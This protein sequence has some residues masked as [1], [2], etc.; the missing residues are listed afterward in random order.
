MPVEQVKAYLMDEN[1][2]NRGRGMY[3]VT[4][5]DEQAK[6]LAEGKAIA[7]AG[8][9]K[10]GER[11]QCCVQFDAAQRQ[12]VLCHPNWFKEAQK[13]GMDMGL[14]QQQKREQSQEQQQKST[15]EQ[16]PKKSAGLKK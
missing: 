13:A 15:Q 6:A 5:S 2:V 7:I 1:G 14:N 9:R 16:G 8:E 3:G 4:F 11:F 10:N 12:V